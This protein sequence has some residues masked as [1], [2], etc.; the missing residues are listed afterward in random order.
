VRKAA[1]RVRISSQLIDATTGHHLWAERYD[2]TV[3]DIFALQDEIVD[4]IIGAL[5]QTLQKA[6]RERAIRKAP[7]NLDAWDCVQRGWWH[8]IQG[9]KEDV[10]K[11][12]SS[13]RKAKEMD[14]HFSIAFSGLA[15]SHLYELSYQWSEAPAQSQAEG[16]GAAE[17]AIALDED[18]P[19]AHVALAMA[20]VS[21]GQY[22]R[23]VA[24]SERAIELNPSAAWGYWCL[25]GSL[26]F[27]GRP[28][29][30]VGLIEKAIRLSPRDPAMHELLFDLGVAHFLAERY[31][32]AIGCEK[33]SLQ[34][35]P[36]Q[37]G[38]YRVLAASYGHLGRSEEARAALDRMREL[39]PDFSLEALR[40]RVP[41][42]VVERYLEGWRKAGLKGE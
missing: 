40:I 23:A 8:L 22:E 10:V 28:D 11:A 16:L 26:S 4:S 6:E 5:Q 12:H 31:E 1:A 38:A 25:G 24:A 37:P 35:R 34:S 39:A 30:G 15:L 7:Q 3:R 36:G 19:Q 33:R 14:P 27:L 9:S 29:E 17:K 2:R 41:P 13:F 20:C 18:E 21:T 42:A 32:E